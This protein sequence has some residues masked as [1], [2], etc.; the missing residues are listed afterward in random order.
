[1]RKLVYALILSLIVVSGLV[2]ANR[3][4]KDESPEKSSSK[5]ISDAER[6]AALKIWETSPD[7]IRFKIWEASP[8]GK[9]VY[10]SAAKI[11]KNIKD[12]SNME[13]TITSL[14]LPTGSLLGFGVMV[15]INDEDYILSFGANKPDEFQKL[16]S[17]KV[18]DKITIKSRG[19]SYAPKYSYPILSGDFVEKN[20][21]LIYKRVASKGGC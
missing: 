14:S 19:V 12:Y 13:A 10:V 8:K 20:N 9:K 17:L 6:K 16:R 21:M 11:R 15:K 18:N 3:R 4:I 7:G 2:F 5:P 1:M